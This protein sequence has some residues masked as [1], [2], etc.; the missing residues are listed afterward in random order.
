MD[1]PAHRLPP[2]RRSSK[3][4]SAITNHREVLP[5]VDGRSAQARRF[6]DIV[7]AIAAD[8]GGLDELAEARLQLIRRFAALAVHAEHLEAKLARGEK[9]DM[10]EHATLSSTLVRIGTRIGIDR[11]IAKDITPTLGTYLDH[12][13]RE[14]AP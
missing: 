14:A 3:L 9:I 6:R 4:R 7:T 13:D 8:Q 5:D 1:M 2:E 12:D 10:L 11:R